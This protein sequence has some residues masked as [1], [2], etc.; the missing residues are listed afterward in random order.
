[1]KARLT[2]LCWILFT[3]L[4]N[5]GAQ[6]TALGDLAMEVRFHYIVNTPF[7]KD[8]ES[9]IDTLRSTFLSLG[10]NGDSCSFNQ[11][12][13][14]FLLGLVLPDEKLLNNSYELLNT[15]SIE[16]YV[17]CAKFATDSTTFEDYYK[18]I[19]G[20]NLYLQATQNSLSKDKEVI[21]LLDTLSQLIVK[22]LDEYTGVDLNAGYR[23]IIFADIARQFLKSGN[24]R[25]ALN[26][27]NEA[28]QANYNSEICINNIPVRYS[29]EIAL[30]LSEMGQYSSAKSYLSYALTQNKYIGDTLSTINNYI[31]LGNVCFNERDFNLS[32]AYLDSALYLSMRFSPM[33]TNETFSER[34]DFFRRSAMPDSAAACYIRSLGG[35]PQTK[36]T[37][38]RETFI[39]SHLGLASLSAS[40]GD[41]D[42]LRLY[43]ETLNSIKDLMND[44]SLLVFYELYLQQNYFGDEISYTTALEELTALEK[45]NRIKEL[46]KK[47]SFLPAEWEKLD[48]LS[49]IASVLEN[50][51]Q[52]QKAT[53]E[54]LSNNFKKWQK[55]TLGIISAL[56]LALGIRT[57]LSKKE[58]EKHKEASL[59]LQRQ[60]DKE[61]QLRKDAEH[62]KE[63][64]EVENNLLNSELKKVENTIDRLKKE[65]EVLFPKNVPI[66]EYLKSIVFDLKNGTHLKGTD[67]IY[68]KGKNKNYRTF[69][70]NDSSGNT[71]TV[72]EQ[73]TMDKIQEV[74]CE[75]AFIRVHQSYLINIMYV[76]NSKGFKPGVIEM[77]VSDNLDEEA[78]IVEVSK[79]NRAKV[80][81]LFRN[82]I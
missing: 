13:S 71:Y 22:Q 19:K 75:P 39:Q 12:I 76:K 30:V 25:M 61:V 18:F 78:R 10:T 66:E 32:R 6:E 63:A 56:L 14:P 54:G 50:D 58:Q 80:A 44:E 51:A 53:N 4:G 47:N 43:L 17:E 35:Y 55:V 52:I 67:I 8:K 70:I 36:Y 59:K 20:A 41:Y 37:G 3:F 1:M 49:Y 16:E 26:Y 42:K 62:R 28:E 46:N 23:R 72:R 60:K 45:R 2:L 48:S 68:V 7:E 65:K 5:L 11:F 27:F 33:E 40:I 57:F 15:W 31:T 82:T 73:A 29:D 24:L 79:K 77:R 69:Y 21:P 9:A 38:D 81:N 64:A 74:L 34:G